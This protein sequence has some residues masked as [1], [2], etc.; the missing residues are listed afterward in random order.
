MAREQ[1]TGQTFVLVA[2]GLVTGAVTAG[3]Y[4]HGGYPGP[5]AATAAI[6]IYVLLLTAHALIARAGR[7]AANA[8]AQAPGADLRAS[9]VQ[10]RREGLA[11][12]VQAHVNSL[13]AAHVADRRVGSRLQAATSP[14]LP[15]FAPTAQ[16]DTMLLREAVGAR[17]S[18]RPGDPQLSP[19]AQALIDGQPNPQFGM[20]D[21]WSFRPAAPRLDLPLV[22]E[23][24]EL[25]PNVDPALTG[26]TAEA[27]LLATQRTADKPASSPREADVEMIQDAIKRLLLEVNAAEAQ[28][29]PAA[30]RAESKRP[31][32][33]TAAKPAAS[34]KLPDQEP[35][36]D[37]SIEALRIAAQSMR[38]AKLPITGGS[39]RMSAMP[40][41]ELPAWSPAPGTS[42]PVRA[43]AGAIMA[44]RIDVALEPIMALEDQRTRHYEVSIRLR[45]ESGEVLDPNAEGVELRGTGLLPL[46]DCANVAR[47]AAMARRLEDRGRQGSLFS[48]FNGESLS[49][50][51]FLG[52][53]A[54]TLHQRAAFAT[55]LVLSFAQSDVRDFS[56]S[57]WDTLADMR[58]LGVRFALNGVTH[59]DMDFEALAEAGFSFVKLDADVF[60]KGLPTA[61]GHIPAG[62]VCRHLAKLGLTLVVE[63]IANEE[64]LARVFGFG[65]LLGQGQLF[66]G[67]RAVRSLG[68][69]SAPVAGEAA[70]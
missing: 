70:A 21:Y 40:S 62:D 20:H 8:A 42:T 17:L 45:G 25:A 19:A 13:R 54:E 3:M 50:D 64:K 24:R 11:D 36:I 65:V 30:G 51:R 29:G 53:L 18:A 44:G 41:P 38:A 1:K 66:G 63:Q 48:S 4:K 6:A 23:E 37:G 26:A 15:P 56:P 47:T 7:N 69:A 22:A 55:Q 28:N 12:G 39:A 33:A 43:I 14:P 57:E 58:A 5:V 46:F 60:L 31:S 32:R 59:L 35:S 49:D 2:I 9:D 67:P 16:E 52:N 61:G 27:D 68:V 34:T 10:R